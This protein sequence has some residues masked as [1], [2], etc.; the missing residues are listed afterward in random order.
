MRRSSQC[1]AQFWWLKKSRWCSCRRSGLQTWTIALKGRRGCSRHVTYCCRIEAVGF[2]SSA[3]KQ[4]P[5]ENSIQNSNRSAFGT[6]RETFAVNQTSFTFRSPAASDTR[7]YHRS[8]SWPSILFTGTRK[9]T[10][11]SSFRQ[12]LFT[13]C[14]SHQ[15][16][17]QTILIDANTNF[18]LLGR[19]FLIEFVKLHV[20]PIAWITQI[21]MLKT[22]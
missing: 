15:L 7:C 3:S 21:Y 8:L 20:N 13:R 5:A 19:L 10:L 22:M 17:T 2:P 11:M 18:S 4:Q 6:W 12:V 16:N 9:A 14:I 1:P